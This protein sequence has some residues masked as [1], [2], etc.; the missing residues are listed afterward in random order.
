[1]LWAG[2]TGVEVK[3]CVKMSF[4]AGRNVAQEISGMRGREGKRNMRQR[5][6]L[7]AGAALAAC[8]AAGAWRPARGQAPGVRAPPG[9]CG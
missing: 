7:A 3:L 9:F 1:M 2:E 4:A 8:L 5:R 6:W